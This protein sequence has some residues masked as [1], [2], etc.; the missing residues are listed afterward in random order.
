[1]ATKSYQLNITKSDGTSETVSFA[2]PDTAGTY[3]LKFTLSNGEEIDAGNITVDDAEHSYDLKLTLS[4]GSVINAG[5]IVTPVGVTAP[6]F[7]SASW[8]E[9]AEI[10]EAG[11]ASA[12]FAVGDEKTIELSTG[13]QLTL[14]ILGFD[15]DDLTD[16]SGKAGMTIGMKNLLATKYRMN[17]TATNSGGWHESE[18]KNVTMATLFSQLPADLQTAI[19]QVEK[20]STAG[21]KS[22]QN[23]I[24][25]D[26]L[27][28]FA[29]V[30]IEGVTTSQYAGMDEGEQYEYWKTVKDGTVEAD[31]IKY[32]SDGGGSASHWWLRSPSLNSEQLF[33]W[34]LSTGNIGGT[35]AQNA[36]GVC[37]GF[38]V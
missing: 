24:S 33:R 4:D 29:Q 38:C 32:L 15:H 36:Q 37:F 35:Y 2:V 3:K 30:E 12:Y 31:R 27:F 22:T 5:T 16:G 21:D 6:V 18:M 9:I 1:M 19:K 26:K 34:I 25:S 17:A 7:A 11:N 13:E 8:A 20:I 28:L 14:V 10:S 23:S